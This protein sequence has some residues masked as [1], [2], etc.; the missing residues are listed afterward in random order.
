MKILVVDDEQLA[1]RRMLRML[2]RMAD[3]EVVGEATDG[4]DAREQI[5]RRA[6]DLV[7]LD[8][9]MPELDGLSLAAE[10]GVPVVFT[11]AHAQHAVEAFDLEAT[12]Y[13]LKPVSE[14]RLR[15]AIDRVRTA[16]S[17]TTQP[18]PDEVPRVSARIGTAAHVFDA[19]T[20]P[21]FFASDKYTLFHHAGDE[22]VLDESL[23][24][25]EQRLSPHGFLRVHRSELIRLA[26][27]KTLHSLDEGPVIE[28]EDGQR[29]AV[30]RRQL[31]ELKRRLGVAVI[32]SARMATKAHLK[33]PSR[34][35]ARHCGPI[36][37][38]AR[39][40]SSPTTAA[41]WRPSTS[42]RSSAPDAAM[43]F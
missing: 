32:T 13:L 39:S 14:D 41:I 22:F 42:G 43:V 38:F 2:G 40:C 23:N 24:A 4:I 8:I 15:R 12:D 26:A 17:P 16:P 21:R 11:T 30:S 33:N 1:R 20:I 7:L 6:P 10:I 25:L 37:R 27:V 31:A 9:D 35:H 18:G 34:R 28:L 19:R 5:A 3:V 29:A 36:S